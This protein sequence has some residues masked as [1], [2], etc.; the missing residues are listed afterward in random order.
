MR[1]RSVVAP[2][3]GPGSGLVGLI[4]MRGATLLCER[5]AECWRPLRSV[6]SGCRAWK[7]QGSRDFLLLFARCQPPVRNVSVRVQLQAYN[8]FNQ[9]NFTV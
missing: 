6:L 2:G 7:V 1:G 5:R 8:L 3:G 4:W 9:V